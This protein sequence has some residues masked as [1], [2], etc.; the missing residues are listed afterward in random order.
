MSLGEVSERTQP[1]NVVG[2]R[3]WNMRDP[4]P[5]NTPRDNPVR[6]ERRIPYD[7][8]ITRA[9]FSAD[10]A[11][12]NAMGVQFGVV[13]GETFEN[14][15]V[16]QDPQVTGGYAAMDENPVDPELMLE[17]EEGTEILAQY[18]N[19]DPN[20]PHFAKSIIYVSEVE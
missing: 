1:E 20:N 7:A 6:V 8:I 2:E 16:P 19:N 18:V 3:V 10:R 15:L 9:Q 14:L 4:V 5:A 12:Q 11:A 17:V 13:G